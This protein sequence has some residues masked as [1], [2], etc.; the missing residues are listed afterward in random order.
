[1]RPKRGREQWKHFPK[2]FVCIFFSLF[3][4][5]HKLLTNQLKLIWAVDILPS[6]EMEINK[7]P[8]S[9][10]I[11]SVELRPAA[12]HKLK[13]RS[14]ALILHSIALRRS[15]LIAR[16]EKHLRPVVSGRRLCYKLV[17]ADYVKAVPRTGTGREKAIS[18]VNYGCR[19]IV[20]ACFPFTR[21]FSFA[22]F[23]KNVGRRGAADRPHSQ[24]QRKHSKAEKIWKYR[25]VNQH[26][27]RENSTCC[28]STHQA[29]ERETR[30]SVCVPKSSNFHV[31][32]EC[33][34]K[35]L[36]E[37]LRWKA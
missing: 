33:G 2:P 7:N 16:K 15:A 28:Q 5:E 20:V 14:N 9:P 6:S 21:F 37:V 13:M 34:T 11:F 32:E 17:W 18:N 29:R 24:S 4:P 35:L 26:K 23:I 1:M 10:P 22:F 3:S 30:C 31:G 8:L 36:C 12:V 27:N 25:R 19:P